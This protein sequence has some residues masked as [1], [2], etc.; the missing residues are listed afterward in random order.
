MNK[1]ISK[2]VIYKCLVNGQVVVKS[3]IYNSDGS[4]DY[5]TYDDGIDA[6]VELLKERNLDS[7]TGMSTLQKEGLICIE[8]EQDF[9]KH[10]IQYER[11][12]L[13]KEDIPYFT[14]VVEANKNTYVEEKEE[15][16]YYDDLSYDEEIED[17]V[18][19]DEPEEIVEEYDTS[20][21]SYDEEI[22]D[23]VYDDEE[24]IIEEDIAINK[25]G[26]RVRKNHLG[27]KI[28]A[29]ALGVIIGLGAYAACNRKSKTGNIKESN[30]PTN[31]I[32]TTTDLN[33]I[34]ITPTEKSVVST[35]T[36]A[37]TKVLAHDNNDLYDGYT[38]AELLSVTNNEFQKNAMINLS[39]SINHFNGPFANAFKQ[40]GSNIKAALKFDEVVALQ[41]AYNTYTKEQIRAYFNG[42]E[43]NAVKLSG[44]YKDASLQLM[45]AHVIETRENQ[46]D[47]SNLIETQE[48][49][50]F[51][52]RYHEM[53]LSAKEATGKEKVRLINEF[54][55]AVRNDFPITKEVR[56]TGISHADDRDSLKDYQLAVTPMI[57][58]SEILFEKV[59]GVNKLS[60]S[61]I[62][63]LNDIGLCNYA[64]DK[65]ER[66]ETITLAAV[67][68]N[69]NPLYEQYK[70]AIV[71]ELTNRDEYVIDNEHRELANLHSFQ[72]K[73]N[74][75]NNSLGRYTTLYS[76]TKF[77]KSTETHKTTKTWT[78]THTETRTETSRTTKPIPQSEKEKIDKEIEKENKKNKTEAER[79]AEEERKRQQEKENKNGQKIREE[80]EKE[81]QDIQ[82]KIDDA[83]KK[84]DNGEKVNEKDLG[85]KVHVDKD[86]KDKDGN[87][88]DSVKNI[89]TDP[90]GADK[91]LPKP[92]DTE[93]EFN[94]RTLKNSSAESS[95]PEEKQEEKK[96]KVEEVKTDD[97]NAY[98]EYD[99]DYVD[100]DENGEPI[101][102]NKTYV[103]KK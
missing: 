51:Y 73:V 71:T 72:V 10:R 65:F 80:V 27:L 60:K 52:N 9:L 62:N 35:N 86:H 103:Y 33:E 56:T 21:Y 84:I 96:P 22:E 45:G 46:V 49:R 25:A 3:C 75:N 4:I 38:L 88:N 87:L 26:E 94:K 68:D 98:I 64:D 66:I 23:V 44:N 89:T 1:K 67:E 59:D 83:N 97:G 79:K 13:P 34:T 99:I 15:D 53:F 69:T 63:F 36:G 42:S 101:N 6:T 43:I 11:E 2:V 37:E 50:D 8:S 55:N 57:A 61:E 39:A 14:K 29:G 32:S 19:V 30:L 77:V 58:A 12:V 100:F 18:E 78:E 47:M 90:S 74:G 70:E 7:K 93:K 40:L 76:D 92:E 5:G 82:N 41:Q 48:G 85:D 31:T 28:L 20:D 91:P 16:I 81:N 95:K 17:Y 24:T 54:Y 102:K